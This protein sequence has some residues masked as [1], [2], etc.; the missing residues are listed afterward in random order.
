[1]PELIFYYSRENRWS[2]NALAAALEGER[3]KGLRLSFP[4]TE[5]EFLRAA[6]AA[7]PG[8]AAAVS[9][10]TCQKK[11]AASLAA[12]LR[13]RGLLLLAGGPHPSALPEEALAMGSTASCPGRVKR[14]WYP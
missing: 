13:G 10:F 1:M 8:T 5:E 14:P 11:A 9:F 4:A 3:I 7:G 12:R 6:L 2:V